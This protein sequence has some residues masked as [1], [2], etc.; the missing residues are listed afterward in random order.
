LHLAARAGAT[1]MVKLLL[2][3]GANPNARDAQGATPSIEAAAHGHRPVVVALVAAG[4][5]V[6]VP[7]YA[8]NTSLQKA[9]QHGAY[10][11]ARASGKNNYHGKSLGASASGSRQ[12]Y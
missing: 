8:A 12:Q 3:K 4:A 9:Q 6:S 11:V 10:L 5:M 1:D 7:D 2:A